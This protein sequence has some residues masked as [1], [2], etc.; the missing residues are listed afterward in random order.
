MAHPHRVGSARAGGCACHEGEVGL[1]RASN[2]ARIISG[3]QPYLL[4]SP[5]RSVRGR[6][7]LLPRPPFVVR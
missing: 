2:R 1:K 4:G 5:S 7:R 6:F 3:Y